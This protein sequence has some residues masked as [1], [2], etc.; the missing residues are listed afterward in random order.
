MPGHTLNATGYESVS[1]SML[2]V[3][4]GHTFFFDPARGRWSRAEKPNPFQTYGH[5][6]TLVNTSKGT[7]VWA[8]LPGRETALYLLDATARTWSKLPITGTLPLTT[9]DQ[10]GVA[11]DAK[12]DRLLLFSGVDKNKGDVMA[13]DMKT[14]A[15]RWLGAAGKA[16]AGVASRN[17]LY[18]PEHGAVLIGNHIQ[19]EG[20]KKLWPL[21][22]CEKNAWFGAEL[23]GVD[24]LAKT[25]FYDL[26]LMYDPQRKL[27]WATDAVNRVHVLKL[28]AKAVSLQKLE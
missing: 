11:Y 14:G 27:I 18:L 28:D 24:P 26:G 15:A 13:Y 17:A 12:S 6:T 4:S 20:G 8:G 3:S 9:Y 22:D 5:V 1:K 21:Y 7:V 19:V 16:G 25:P 23:A 2:Y 10:H